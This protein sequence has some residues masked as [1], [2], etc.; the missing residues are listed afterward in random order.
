MTLIEA[1]NDTAQT[2][3]WNETVKRGNELMQKQGEDHE[4]V[5]YIPGG[6]KDGGDYIVRRFRTERE[7]KRFA[8]QVKRSTGQQYSI[9]PA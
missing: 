2:Q 6:L 8:D 7:A 9:K 4:H 3:K 5:V 1:L